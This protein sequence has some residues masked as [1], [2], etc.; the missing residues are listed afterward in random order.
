M[1]LKHICIFAL[2]LP[3]VAFFSCILISLFKDFESA[4]STHCNVYNI[5]PSISASISKFY[6]QIAVWRLLI[7]IDS[8]PRYFIAY[9]YFHNYYLPKKEYLKYSYCYE[10]LIRIAFFIHIIELTSLLLLSYISSVEIFSVHKI[11]FIAF[12][13]S[14]SMYMLLS[15]LT[16]FWPTEQPGYANRS[17]KDYKSRQMK[18][19][20]IILYIACLIMALYFYI[21]HNIRCEPYIYSFFSLFEYM[22]VLTNIAYHSVIFYDMSL[23]KKEYRISMLE[24][25]CKLNYD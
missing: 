11:S 24:N 8:F 1:N 16:H 9:V 3:L 10:G 2:I 15:V 22:T 14:S 5:L 17:V 18:L 21:R 20:I 19:G 7:G 23:F 12:L 13:A 6:P 25:I 4:N